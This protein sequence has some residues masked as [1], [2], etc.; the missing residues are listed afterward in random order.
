MKRNQGAGGANTNSNGH[1][2]ED[3]VEILSLFDENYSITKSTRL[4]NEVKNMSVIKGNNKIYTHLKYKGALNNFFSERGVTVCPTKNNSGVLSKGLGPDD[5]IYDHS[6]DTLMIFEKK[7]QDGPGSVDE[8]L[9][10]CDFKKKQYTKLCNL[11][12]AKVEYVFI[13]SPYFELNKHIYKDVFEY[14]ESV[15]CRYYFQS[16]FSKIYNDLFSK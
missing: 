9:Q 4:L 13:L 15:G 16:N 12:G 5:A 7:F 6:S 3:M 8:K 11:I 1:K 14:I 10:T 2:F